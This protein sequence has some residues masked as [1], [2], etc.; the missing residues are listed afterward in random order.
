MSDTNEI[1]DAKEIATEIPQPDTK[2]AMKQ[3]K[4]FCKLD[5][6]PVVYRTKAFT[7][8]AEIAMRLLEKF[9][10]VTCIEDGEDSAGRQKLKLMDPKHVVD[11]SFELA[12]EFMHQADLG[13]YIV[14]I[15][16][17]AFDVPAAE[18]LD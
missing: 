17:P 18:D 16:D 1:L 10:M 6:E 8:T 3:N 4:G 14:D 2:V 11:R 13:N 12:E 7:L 5:L 15:P 9:A